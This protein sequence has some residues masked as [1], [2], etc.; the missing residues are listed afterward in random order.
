MSVSN[1]QCVCTVLCASLS[2]HQ[3]RGVLYRNQLIAELSGGGSDFLFLPGS[4]P[5][6]CKI[7]RLIAPIS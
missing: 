3:S 5:R 1:L 2:V 7:Y 6:E 4:G